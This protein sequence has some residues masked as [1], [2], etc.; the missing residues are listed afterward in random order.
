MK[1][2]DYIIKLRKEKGLTQKQLAASLGISNTAVSKWECGCNLPDISMVEPICKVLDADMFELLSYLN[3]TNVSN[4]DDS[5]EKEQNKNPKLVFIISLVILLVL[6]SIILITFTVIKINYKR[7]N[8]TKEVKVYEIKSFEENF[9]VNGYLMFNKQDSMVL[10]KDISYQD[11]KRGIVEELNVQ[12]IKISLE[13]NEESVF[14]FAS[15]YPDDKKFTISEIIE[16]IDFNNESF[17]NSDVN[18]YSS[19][20]FFSN[21][22]L[23]VECYKKDRMVYENEQ[24][25]ALIRKFT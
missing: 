10:I 15:S 7:K 19:E 22:K 16:T 13:I 20:E 23:K 3:N 2:E 8:D 14:Y 18:L 21:A 25:I 17:Y 1:L 9:T 11:T 5:E 12:N 24:E 6:I 4:P